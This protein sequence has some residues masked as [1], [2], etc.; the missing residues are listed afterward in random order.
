MTLPPL[1]DINAT[2]PVPAPLP[3]QPLNAPSPRTLIVLNPHAGGGRAGKLWHRI[4]PLLW[5]ALGELVIAV[6]QRPE[7]VAEHLDKAQ[8]AGLTRV[9]AI[10]G[11][12]TNHALINE[13]LR[14]QTAHPETPPMAFGTLPVGT[15][16][17]WARTFKIPFEP[18]QAVQWIARAQPHPVDIGRVSF[19]EQRL[20]F[21]NIASVGLGGDVA[22]RVNRT[23]R[24]R[25]WTFYQKTVESLLWYPPPVVT[26]KLDGEVWYEGKIYAC[27]VANGQNFGHG[28]QIAPTAL[29]DDGLFD[30]VIIE[31]MPR[32]RAV[33][34]LNTVYDGSHIKRKDVHVGRGRV[35]E[36]TSQRSLPMEL[37][38]ESKSGSPIRFELLAGALQMLM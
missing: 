22:I 8:A 36:V 7:E 24:R 5:T 13:L 4:E 26:I 15:G 29:V 21:L 20:H 31:G 25:P 18:E 37:D 33:Q 11:D 9:I 17:D 38:G 23:V 32:L 19:G 28:M 2:T 12:G 30:L 3:A 27:V 6:T 34:A 10:G 35:V 14:L 16:R 1:A